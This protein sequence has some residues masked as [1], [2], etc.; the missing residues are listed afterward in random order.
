MGD[1][2]P[3]NQRSLRTA[4]M[5]SCV[6]SLVF[7]AIL[8]SV[9]SSY[10]EADQLPE[11]T[12]PEQELTQMK[13]GC[14]RRCQVYGCSVTVFKHC[15]YGG[16][17][18][19][20]TPGSYGMNTLIRR[21]MRN[22]DLSSIQV[23]G[24]C[25]AR[26]YEHAW[27][28]GGVLTRTGNDSCFT[29]D[30]LRMIQF[31]EGKRPKLS[32]N[33]RI[34]IVEHK[35][36]KEM[37]LVQANAQWGRRRRRRYISWNDQISSIRVNNRGTHKRCWWDCRERDAKQ[38]ERSNKERVN[39][40][41][42]NKER[43]NKERRNKERYN[44][45]RASK[46][47]AAKH[48]ERVAKE[49]NNKERSNKERQLKAERRAKQ[50]RERAI[51]AHRERT[52]K[53]NERRAKERANKEK[54]SKERTA[55]ERANKER[56][57]KERNNKER[58]A[59]ERSNKERRSKAGRANKERVSKER[60]NKER[61]A[62]HRERVNKERANKERRNKERA[63]KEKA[64]KHKERVHKERASKERTAKERNNKERAAKQRERSN[65]ERSK[66]ERTNKERSRKEKAAKAKV[67]RDQKAKRERKAKHDEK[68]AKEKKNKERSIKAAIKKAE[69][70]HSKA[71]RG[72][73]AAKKE[74][75]G[76][77][78]AWKKRSEQYR[79]AYAKAKESAAK[80]RAKANK[81]AANKK[82][83][84]LGGMPKGKFKFSPNPC[85][86]GSGKFNQFIKANQKVVIG[87]IPAKQNNV[88]IYLKSPKDVDVELWDNTGKKPLGVI[89]SN[90]G[91][92]DSAVTAKTDYKGAK[93]TYSGYNGVTSGG[94]M[95]LGHEFI[96]IKGKASVPLVMKAFGFAAGKAHVTY[97]WGAD[98][99]ACA[100]ENAKKKAKAEKGN[101]ERKHKAREMGNKI[102]KKS[103]ASLAKLAKHLGKGE[104]AAENRIKINQVTGSAA[105][106]KCMGVV[107]RL[108]SVHNERGAKVKAA[109]GR[110]KTRRV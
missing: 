19:N 29:N 88:E 35:P 106:K 24:H 110:R 79:K 59:K 71:K 96:K 11:N 82:K 31:P 22:D 30:R 105:R 8:V 41:R 14:Q 42:S 45:E 109:H 56:A 101:K 108:S 46:E 55:K 78:A 62:K 34:E 103:A 83:A 95:N 38:R 47:R 28:N 67:E 25:T 17:R 33:F 13:G 89:A 6:I 5:K 90:G 61:A 7:V 70:A 81:E 52:A 94:K 73:S 93:V 69:E 18:I 100:G 74:C 84:A 51:K 37:E 43:S 16:Y 54:T 9:A 75:K 44:K 10:E 15:N 2:E 36:K 58:T 4:I 80:K 3:F 65:K 92:I 49:R 98:K 60:R 26:L 104:S 76:K 53:A 57:H 23:H 85:H 48:R 21:G 102:N 77:H 87:T 99:E 27:F 12:A 64:A 32:K 1:L 86:G 68:I 63:N 72:E 91:R 107:G 66:K 39:K 50:A 20:L 97:R 40:E